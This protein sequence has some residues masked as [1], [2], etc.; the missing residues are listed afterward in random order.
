[1]PRVPTP[2]LRAVEGLTEHS[3]RTLAIVGPPLSGKSAILAELSSRLQPL[4]TRII[5]LRG[6]YRD[7]EVPYA[8]LEGLRPPRPGVLATTPEEGDGGEQPDGLGSAVAVP[9]GSDVAVPRGRRRRGERARWSILGTPVRSRSANE[10]DPEAYWDDLRAEF[11][12]ARAH[13]VAILAED[14]AL[15]DPSS[16]EFL[17]ALSR[18]VRLRPLLLALALD[19]SVA[20]SRLWEEPLFGRGDVDW[21]RLREAAPDAREMAHLRSVYLELPATAQRVVGI[22]ALLGGEATDVVLARAA[23]LGMAQLGEA[24]APASGLGLI[25]RHEGKVELVP[26]ETASIVPRFLSEEANRRMHG[27][28]ADALTA[29][30][31]EPTLG[32]RIEVA[33]HLLIGAPGPSAIARLEEAAELSLR[34]SAYDTAV[35][36]LDDAV[37]CLGSVEEAARI[38]AEPRLRL[39]RA[40]ALF[41]AGLP[42]EGESEAREGVE[43]AIRARLSAADLAERVEPLLFAMRA[44]GPRPS[45]TMTQ[46]ELAERCHE[47]GLTEVELEFETILADAYTER[48]QQDRARSAAV[49]AERIARPLA[50]PHLQAYGMLARGLVQI[51]GNPVEQEEAERYLRSARE[52]FGTTRRWELDYMAGD[53]EARLLELRGQPDRALAL[54][55]QCV[56]TLERE[57]PRFVELA[58]RVGI[59]EI[60]LDRG[61]TSGLVP[62]LERA[63]AIAEALHLLPPSPAFLRLWLLEGRWNAIQGNGERAR[64]C[65][66]ALADLPPA[67]AVPQV[68]AEALVRLALLERASDRPE[69]ATGWEELLT[70][71]ETLTALPASWRP[72]VRRLEEISLSSRLGG[73]RLPPGPLPSGKGQ[74]NEGNAPGA[75]P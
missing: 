71:R 72:W 63:H 65:W 40:V 10:G 23:R 42:S 62:T 29:L 3:G 69:V 13:P 64:D 25:R 35:E 46:L 39:L 43:G 60:L 11:Q 24:V 20:D 32:R 1:M 75:S 59:A 53:L 70:S 12:G 16:R 30:S 38:A 28:I 31:P 17:V 58:H 74:R 4:G 14:A 5:E 19:S 15:F 34:L 56:A 44:A 66:Q 8:A 21:V 67:K 26:R 52:L 49:H 54:R 6:S 37:S 9:F 36:L 45:L 18:R 51:H 57:R 73:G 55:Q 47:A 33:R 2:V 50:E 27:E 61:T 22:L 41:R 68:R 7:R 48:N